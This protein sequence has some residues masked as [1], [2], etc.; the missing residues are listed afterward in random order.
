M[1]IL[2][3]LGFLVLTILPRASAESAEDQKITYLLSD[4]DHSSEKGDFETVQT[5]RM[6]LA[7]YAASIG[8]YDLASRQYELLLAGRPGRSD[9]VRYFKRL[10]KARMAQEDYGRAIGAFDDALHYSPQDWEAKLER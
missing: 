1:K 2:L 3:L 5:L 7:D 9:R 8:R 10:G 6:R 4:I